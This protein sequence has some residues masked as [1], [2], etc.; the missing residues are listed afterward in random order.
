LLVTLAPAAGAAI[1]LS[2]Q[3]KAP[4]QVRDGDISRETEAPFMLYGDL[5]VRGLPHGINGETYWRAYDDFGLSEGG[6]DFYAGLV[7]APGVIPFV[8]DLSLG[9]QFLGE[10]PRGGFLADAGRVTLDVGAPVNF[11]VFGGQP[12]YFEPTTD[13]S[14]IPRDEQMF[15]VRANFTRLARGYVNAG[16]L[17]HIRDGDTLSQLITLNAGRSYPRLPGV[18]R[19]YGS[20]A[21]DAHQNI[22]NR[23]QFGTQVVVLQPRLLGGIDFT[24][25]DP[26]DDSDDLVRDAAL[27][28][29]PLFDIFS[30]SNQTQVTA[31]A[32]YI[33]SAS[34]SASANFGYQRYE[35]SEDVHTDGY[36]GGAGIHWLPEGDGLE[37]VRLEYYITD[38]SG[39]T[40]N[41]GRLAYDNWVYE[42]IH[43]RT[44]VD[45]GYYEKVTNQND[46]AVATLMGLG[47]DV[48]PGLYCEA[49][50]EGN[51]NER[52]DADV[53]FGLYIVYDWY[54]RTT[55]QSA[56]ATRGEGA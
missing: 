38:G 25:Y 12:R 21:Y 13:S 48:L 30:I 55:Q 51:R 40:V 45:I 22:V 7:R 46:T 34:L 42:R 24:Y 6:G 11:S 35:N 5:G 41:G 2:A 47:Y 19:F 29:D 23:G 32:R 27:R 49:Y 18:P 53:R 20:F 56:P 37:L 33:L 44:K 26:S 4:G 43:F 17:Q 36:I 10:G 3:L 31:T 50:V 9:R 52:F 15:G 8:S 28:E 1:D 54:H 16:F 14:R 39:G